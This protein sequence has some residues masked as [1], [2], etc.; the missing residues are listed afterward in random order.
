[1]YTC[2]FDLSLSLSRSHSCSLK[3]KFLFLFSHLSVSIK[4][5][6]SCLVFYFPVPVASGSRFV[7]PNTCFSSRLESVLYQLHNIW[8]HILCSIMSDVCNKP[9]TPRTHNWVV[10]SFR[11]HVVI[12]AA[13][14][15]SCVLLFRC[16]LSCHEHFLV[17]RLTETL[18]FAVATFLCQQSAWQPSKNCWLWA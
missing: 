2:L 11:R 15:I 6:S 5:R 17:S 1:M 3:F 13:F 16:Q 18:Y 7:Y 9:V 12:Y 4:T 8:Q 14:L 10:M